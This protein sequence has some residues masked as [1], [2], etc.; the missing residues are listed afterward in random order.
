MG[1]AAFEEAGLRWLAEAPA[2]DAVRREIAARLNAIEGIEGAELIKRNLVRAVFRV[3]LASGERVIVKRYAVR[4]VRDP[5]KYLFKP[6]RARAEWEV[7]RGLAEAGISTAVPL[8]MAERRRGVL[9]DAALVTREIPDTLHL[10]AYVEEH[11]EEGDSADDMRAALYERL[12]RLVRR[13]HA[14]GFVHN[15]LHGGNVLVNGP[16][17]AACPHVIDLHSV[18][19]STAPS[20]GKRWFDLVKLLHSMLTCST[21]AERVALCRAYEDEGGAPSGTDLTGLLVSGRLSEAL[22]AR[23]ARMERKRVRSRTRRSLERSSRFDVS[24]TGP[25]R[26]HHLRAVPAAAFAALL[27]AH[28]EALAL[29]GARVLKDARRSALTRQT[30]DTPAGSEPVIVKQYRLGRWPERLKNLL[31]RPRP[32]SAWVA[33]NGLRVRGFEVAEPLALLL[34][35]RG[36]L[37]REAYIVMRDMGD[38]ARADLVVLRRYAGDLDRAARDEKLRLVR[39]AARLF[40]R[41]HAA[42]VY[43]GDLKAVN[44]FVSHGARGPRIVLADYDRVRFGATVSRRRRVKNLAQLSASVPICITLADRLRFFREYTVDDVETAKQWKGWFQAVSAE[45]RRKIVVRMQPIE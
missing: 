35:G 13:M 3:P 28:H 18:S 11:L 26:A 9:R 32:L 1:F 40:R 21:P 20:A 14:A 37:A 43:H 36:V 7:G 2:A 17:E 45:C 10:N 33:G 38:D 16:P 19:R 41:L 6:S 31:R 25:F 34:R 4:G 15:D 30:L 22:E 23:I 5:V 27:P 42:D 8:A 29:G 44:L 39:A 24:S 12:A